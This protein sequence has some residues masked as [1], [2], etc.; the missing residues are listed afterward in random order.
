MLN[1]EAL[2]QICNDPS[3]IYPISLACQGKHETS[4]NMILPDIQVLVMEVG[5]TIQPKI[6]NPLRPQTTEEAANHPK[7]LIPKLEPFST[8]LT[9]QLHAKKGNSA[10]VRP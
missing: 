7:W 8:D 1:L 4:V 3:H 2:I 10:F 5:P 9:P 6:D